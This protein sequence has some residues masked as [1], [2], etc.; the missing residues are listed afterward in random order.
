MASDFLD[1]WSQSKHSEQLPT[2]TNNILP[3]ALG[4]SQIHQIKILRARNPKEIFDCELLYLERA[5][6]PSCN[7]LSYVLGDLTDRNDIVCSGRLVRVMKNLRDALVRIRRPDFDILV[8]ADA[9]CIYSDQT[10]K[11]RL[12]FLRF[13]FHLLKSQIGAVIERGNSFSRSAQYH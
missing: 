6:A 2:D 1:T 3:K 9:L 4:P 7:A 12:K 13:L 10:R 5:E 11:D 8:W